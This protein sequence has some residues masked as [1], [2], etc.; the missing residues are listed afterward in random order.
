MFEDIK[1]LG[2]EIPYLSYHIFD[3]IVFFSSASPH[4]LL[5]HKHPK[6]IFRC[7]GIRPP[8]LQYM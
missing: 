7:C 4:F 3:L 8:P 1:L 2:V 5:R 6:K